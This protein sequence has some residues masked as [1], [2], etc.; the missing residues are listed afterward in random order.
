[1]AQRGTIQAVLPT[2]YLYIMCRKHRITYYSTDG[3]SFTVHKADGTSCVL[4]LPRGGYY[5]L[6]LNVMF[7]LINTVDS[8]KNK[9]TV[10]EYSDACKGR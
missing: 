2:S 6:M 9:Y 10:K 1:M 4:N 5:S 3:I 8:I 7:V